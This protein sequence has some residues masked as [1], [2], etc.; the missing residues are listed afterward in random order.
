MVNLIRSELYR[1]V[2]SKCTYIL[3]LILAV[4]SILN[5]FM[6]KVIDSIEIDMSQ[7]QVSLKLLRRK[8]PRKSSM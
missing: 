8:C 7:V 3:L 6:F 1:L 2:K 5:P 4:F